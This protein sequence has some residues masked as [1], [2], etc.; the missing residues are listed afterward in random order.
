[1]Y[2]ACGTHTSRPHKVADGAQ[3]A[4]RSVQA[5]HK[6]PSSHTAPPHPN[7]LLH[8]LN[9]LLTKPPLQFKARAFDP[10]VWLDTQSTHPIAGHDAGQPPP[11]AATLVRPRTE[12]PPS[13]RH[14]TCSCLRCRW[15]PAAQ[16]GGKGRQRQG[17]P[18]PR[19]RRHRLGAP[20]WQAPR[21]QQLRRPYDPPKGGEQEVLGACARCW[22]QHQ[23]PLLLDAMR[24]V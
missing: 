23:L 15:L 11:A 1:M 18:R 9:A 16:C 5:V 14:P 6:V 17:A 8:L 21:R 4:S 22:H 24:S 10:G 19:P 20:P 13:H 12:P 3:D 2:C 7:T